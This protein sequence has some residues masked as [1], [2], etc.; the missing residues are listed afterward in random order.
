MGG[1]GNRGTLTGKAPRRNPGASLFC[2]VGLFTGKAL[3][4]KSSQLKPNHPASGSVVSDGALVR[5]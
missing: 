2:V 3:G 5:Y 4:G 1:G